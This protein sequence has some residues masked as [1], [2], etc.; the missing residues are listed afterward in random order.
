MNKTEPVGRESAAHPAFGIIPS[1][2]C[3]RYLLPPSRGYK[4]HAPRS[5]E[6]WNTANLR[7]SLPDHALPDGS[8]E[9]LHRGCRKFRLSENFLNPPKSPFFKGGLSKEFHLVPPMAVAK[10]FFL[11]PLTLT[12]S[13]RWGRGDKRKKLLASYKW[14]AAAGRLENLPKVVNIFGQEFPAAFQEGDRE[15]EGAAG[16]KSAEVLGQ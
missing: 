9:N 13:P 2:D 15:D 3:E 10:S 16:N 11:S 8:G 5:D 1:L 12:L 4:C 7:P 14:P 6:S